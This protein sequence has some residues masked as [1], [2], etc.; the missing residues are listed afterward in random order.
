MKN[1]AQKIRTSHCGRL[2]NPPGFE[3]MAFRL[4]SGQAT[5]DDV[6]SRVIPVVADTI[7]HQV[8]IGI[9]CIGDGEFWSGLGLKWYEQQMSG[10]S[11]RP[12][13]EGEVAAMRESTRER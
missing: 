10:L 7:K 13:K 12:L 11:T 8:E 3:D 5:D 1:S 4:A 9:D 6:K 2:P